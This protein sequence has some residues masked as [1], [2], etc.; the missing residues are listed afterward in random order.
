MTDYI[1]TTTDARANHAAHLAHGQPIE[2]DRERVLIIKTGYS[3]TLDPD[4]SGIVSLGDV[5]RSTVILSLLPE[6]D[7]HVSWVVDESA[8]ALLDG[9]PGIDELVRVT[10]STVER[11]ADQHHDIVIN[12]EKSEEICR[13]AESI[14]AK[15]HV[16]FRYCDINN[17]VDTFH[18]ADHVISITTDREFKRRQTKS[19]SELLFEM[20]GAT[21]TDEPCIIAPPD[22]GEADIY[23][24]G[25]NWQV[26]KKFPLK[27]WPKENWDKLAQD[28]DGEHVVCWQQS[29]NDLNGYI[30]W[31][32]ACRVLIT[33]DSLGLHL[34]LALG[35]K[36]VALF[37]PTSAVEIHDHPNVIKLQPETDWDCIPCLESQCERNDTCMAHISLERVKQAALSLLDKA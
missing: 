4:D 30:Q 29:A 25:L 11:I 19:W 26:G 37:G 15:V 27:G 6:D 12:L 9:T 8:A 1:V 32:N 14:D 17:R 33:N 16:G 20:L 34:A 35:K 3:E 5:L 13:L 18:D 21:Y 7:Y 2:Q 23:D 28:L 24:F 10:S 31:I 36:V 22:G